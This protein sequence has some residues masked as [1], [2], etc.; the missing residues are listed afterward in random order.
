MKGGVWLGERSYGLY[1]WHFPVILS[2]FAI[3]SCWRPT[4]DQP[5]GTQGHSDLGNLDCLGVWQLLAG[6]AARTS[7][8]S[9]GRTSV[10]RVATAA[11]SIQKACD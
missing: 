11:I 9:T 6:G 10:E 3:G 5:P 8:G 2:V 4:S 7:A 1:L